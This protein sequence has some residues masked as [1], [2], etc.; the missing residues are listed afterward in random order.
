MNRALAGHADL[1]GPPARQQLRVKS[2][3]DRACSFERRQI[4]QPSEQIVRTVERGGPAILVETLQFA[5]EALER[6]R[7][8]SSRQL[9]GADELGEHAAV[10]GEGLG[11]PFGH[12]RVVVVHELGDVGEGQRAGKRRW[13][14]GVDGGDAD[15]PRLHVA[16]Q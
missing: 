9:I 6:S 3:D 16:H 12:G 11:A 10:E 4:A 7:S 2:S 14:G 1:D 8:M 15:S 13:L 5:L